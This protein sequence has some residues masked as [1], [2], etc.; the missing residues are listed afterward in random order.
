VK[1]LKN[2]FGVLA[3]LLAVAALVLFFIPFAQVNLTDGST[4]KGV[5]AE[6]AIGSVN[7]QT[8]GKSSDILFCGILTI[9][10][11]VFAALSFKFKG[12]R[13][14]TIGFSIVDAVYMLVVAL[15]H[16]NK[17]VD[18][19]NLVSEKLIG[20]NTTAYLNNAPL[21]ISIALFLTF[22]AAVAYLLIADKIAV[23]EA[24]EATLTIPQKVIKFLKDYKGE[25]KKIVWP[26]PKSV[27]KNTVIVLIMCVVIGAFIWAIDIGLNALL[28][29]IYK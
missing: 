22:A 23:A 11:V 1:I 25:I 4:V 19:Q 2:V 29:L 10:T 6:F 28:R 7:G 5:A 12:S 9:L 27:V 14:A 18:V 21:L 20:D 17:F 24:E 16:S 3:V 13:W 15:F 26:G 8:I